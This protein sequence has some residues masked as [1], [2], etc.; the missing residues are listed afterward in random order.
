MTRNGRFT[1]QL[2][3]SVV[4]SPLSCFVTFCSIDINATVWI[5]AGLHRK[6]SM[7]TD[8]L[9]ATYSFLASLADITLLYILPQERHRGILPEALRI[10][11]HLAVAFTSQPQCVYKNNRLHF[12]FPK[13]L[14]LGFLCLPWNRSEAGF[15]LPS[16]VI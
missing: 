5:D 8:N 13:L 4:V 7:L 6:D 1:S 16:E 14:H 3:S 15:F 10:Q 12:V 11:R 2:V 9:L